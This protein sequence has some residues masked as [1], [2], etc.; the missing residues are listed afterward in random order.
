MPT[1]SLPAS[2]VQAILDA[3]GRGLTN[4][5]VARETKTAV[6]TVSKV[7]NGY[8]RGKAKELPG[9]VG[10]PVDARGETTGDTTIVTPDKPMSEAEMAK[11]FKIDTKVWVCTGLR[12]NVWQGFYKASKITSRTATGTNTQ[13]A[14]QKVALFQTTASWKRILG[15]S[16]QLRL[17][18]FFRDNVLPLA[19]PPIGPPLKNRKFGKGSGEMVSWGLWDAHLG[20]YAWHREVGES[21]D[22]EKAVSRV[23]NSI[24]DIAAELSG[25][26]IEQIVMPI[27]NDFMHY[28]NLEQHTTYGDHHLDADGRYAK[29]Y[30]A[31]L[32]CLVYMIERALEVCPNVK[33][34]YVPGNHDL[35]SSYTLCVALSQR[36]LNDPRV[37]FDLSANPR[38]YVTF[39]GTLLGF[40][41]GQGANAKQLAL[42][43]ATEC[44]KVWSGSTYREVQVG[45]T[46]QKRVTEFESVTPT[47]GVT[48]R[49]NPALSAVDTWHHTQGLIGEPM[50]SVSAWRYDRTG[51]RGEHVAWA[52]DDENRITKQV[53]LNKD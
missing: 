7:L 8:R 35:T 41:H 29:V 11:L 22:L 21:M 30:A 36:F 46:H 32:R 17:L 23:T 2:K 26:P 37:S 50:K 27:G 5:E 6:G 14:H 31:G 33:V 19:K 53:R 39:G 34:L 18:D 10:V 13:A 47:N 42:I 51:Y 20:L 43:Y 12:T 52:R 15:E 40:D 48:I 44:A 45:H 38:K 3:A 25:H 49:V 24:D 4:A 16:I 1:P 28:D 9:Q